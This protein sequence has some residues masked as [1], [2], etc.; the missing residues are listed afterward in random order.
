MTVNNNNKTYKINK[1]NYEKNHKRIAFKEE[2]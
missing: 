1:E 2:Q